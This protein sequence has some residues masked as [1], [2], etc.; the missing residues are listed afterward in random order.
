MA[1]SLQQT[2]S[3]SF[4]PGFNEVLYYFPRYQKTG[5]LGHQKCHHVGLASV[6]GLLQGD[7][8]GEARQHCRVFIVVLKLSQD[9]CASRVLFAFVDIPQSLIKKRSQTILVVGLSFEHFE[10]GEEEEGCSLV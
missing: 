4:I 9:L 5:I 1:R 2:H 7:L 6:A 8:L 10:E 3:H